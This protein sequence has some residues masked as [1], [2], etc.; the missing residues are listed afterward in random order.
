L[1]RPAARRLPV[2]LAPSAAGTRK[3]RPV[4]ADSPSGKHDRPP[5]AR[6]RAAREQPA[7][8]PSGRNPQ[9]QQRAELRRTSRKLDESRQRNL[10][11]RSKSGTEALAPRD[12]QAIFIRELGH[13]NRPSGRRRID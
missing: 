11:D 10:R 9:P 3:G 8:R 1:P 5:R 2:A 7:L 4:Q 6:T 12:R 13:I